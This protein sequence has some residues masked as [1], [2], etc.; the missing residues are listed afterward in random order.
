MTYYRFPLHLRP[1]NKQIQQYTRMAIDI[2]RDLEL[3]QRHDAIDFTATRASSKRMDAVRAYLG[4]YLI[5]SRPATPWKPRAELLRFEDWTATC[6]ELFADPQSSASDQTLGWHIRLQYL[7]T[8]T[9]KLNN[10]RGGGD[11]CEE[12]RVLLLLKG[13]EAQFWDFQ[14]QMSAEVASQRE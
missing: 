3:D 1:K 2:V 4:A 10:R 11:Y 14:A 6:C 13:M 7:L 5:C 12:Q 9:I 8:E